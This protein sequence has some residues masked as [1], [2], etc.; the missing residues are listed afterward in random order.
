MDKRIPQLLIDADRILRRRERAKQK[1]LARREAEKGLSRQEIINKRRQEREKQ[2]REKSAARAAKER[3]AAARAL[4]RVLK[5]KALEEKT[6]E[7]EKAQALRAKKREAKQRAKEEKQKRKQALEE[8]MQKAAEKRRRDH[9]SHVGDIFADAGEKL[10]AAQRATDDAVRFREEK[11]KAAAKAAAETRAAETRAAETRAKEER[12]R[13]KEE[14]RRAKEERRRAK[15]DKKKSREEMKETKKK[16]KE[17]KKKEEAEKTENARKAKEEAKKAKEAKKKEEREAKEKAKEKAKE[18]AEKAKEERRKAEKALKETE[19][20]RRRAAREEERKIKIAQARLERQLELSHNKIHGDIS[21]IALKQTQKGFVDALQQA[22]KNDEI[23]LAISCPREGEPATAFAYQEFVSYAMGPHSPCKRL[24]CVHRTGAGKTLTIIKILENNFNDPRPKLVVFP[25]KPVAL[26]FYSEIL[27]FPNVYR[28]F[29]EEEFRGDR[30]LEVL[31]RNDKKHPNFSRIIEKVQDALGLKNKLFSGKL[32]APLRAFSYSELGGTQ[33][34]GAKRNMT[35]FPKPGLDNKIILMDEA[36]NLVYPGNTGCGAFC[37]NLLQ[38]QQGLFEATN[39]TLCGFTA[40]PITA[41]ESTGDLLMFIIRGKSA[42]SSKPKEYGEVKEL[43]QSFLFDFGEDEDDRI[44]ETKRT[45]SVSV[46]REIETKL[47]KQRKDWTGFVSYFYSQPTSTFPEYLPQ[48][49]QIIDMAKSDGLS[50][51]YEEKA[52][53]IDIA[54][55]EAKNVM[56]LQNYCNASF[57]PTLRK[58]KAKELL[59]NVDPMEACP[60]FVKIAQHVIESSKKTLI[61]IDRKHNLVVLAELINQMGATKCKDDN[62][63]WAKMID[64]ADE[65][66]DDDDDKRITAKNKKILGVFNSKEND[67]GQKIKCLLIDAK[68]YSEGVSFFGVRELHIVNP[69]TTYALHLQRVGRVF[70]SCR[71][72]NETRDIQQKPR[73]S[74]LSSLAKLEE[75]HRPASL[76]EDRRSTIARFLERRR[77]RLAAAARPQT[78]TLKQKIG[79]FMWM[80]RSDTILT[81][82][83]FAFESLLKSKDQFVKQMGMFENASIDKG[84]YDKWDKVKTGQESLCGAGKDDDDDEE[85]ETFDQRAENLRKELIE[86]E[87]KKQAQE[88]EGRIARRGFERG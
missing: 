66:A 13:A 55:T 81:A 43:A 36:H 47:A 83:E 56:R 7:K 50:S 85:M 63:W 84:L 3:E 41:T 20:A 54:K 12:R 61:I 40:T 60:K 65:L 53:N 59:K 75:E 18:E 27:E 80:T 52:K 39:T 8:R 49:C 64:A 82:D 19:S 57:G 48:K 10:A 29:L 32:P 1:K 25:N 62:C 5:Q 51:K 46:I 30:D 86:K 4:K 17:A 73:T 14:R 23:K 88:R 33:V 21:K 2:A 76:G 78:Q 58:S 38:L 67:F 87:R 37:S 22:A 72:V 16:A 44:S 24:L 70:R 71:F 11:R 26:N 15:E 6:R 9:A 45:A 28:D 42:S 77:L 79:V 68:T 74:Q 34:F 35:I 31:R 69:A